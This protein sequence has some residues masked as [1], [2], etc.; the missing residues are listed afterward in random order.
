MHHRAFG[1]VDL[2]NNSSLYNL[3]ESV[4]AIVQAIKQSLKGRVSPLVVSLDGGS[5]AGKSTLASEVASSVGATVIQCDDFFAAQIPD[6]EWDT[7][8]PDQK[9]RRCIEWERVRTEALLPL[10]AGRKVQYHPFSFSNTN[11]LSSKVVLKEPS[12]VII[13]DGIYSSQW[14]SDLVNLSVLVDAPLNI[15]RRRHN[16]RE[17]DEDT[18][19]HLRWDS[20]EDYYFSVLRAPDS[21]D[22]VVVNE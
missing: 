16:F 14:L 3:K 11:G 19:W 1:V 9:C 6:E 13:L 7:Y 2:K 10:L 12:K 17:G 8:S 18:D 15:R 20:V 4:Q 22:L 21:F 5:G